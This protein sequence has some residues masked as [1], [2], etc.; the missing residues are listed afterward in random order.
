MKNANNRVLHVNWINLE[1][2]IVQRNI[3]LSKRGNSYEGDKNSTRPLVITS[4]I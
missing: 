3:Q 2:G 1:R 4:E